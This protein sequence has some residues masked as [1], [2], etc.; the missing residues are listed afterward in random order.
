MPKITVSF[1]FPVSIVN[2]GRWK[3]QIPALLL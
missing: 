3:S 2:Y 1:V